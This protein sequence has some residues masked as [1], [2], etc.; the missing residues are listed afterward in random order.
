MSPRESSGAAPPGQGDP[1]SRTHV[2]GTTPTRAQPAGFVRLRI[3]W[4]EKASRRAGIISNCYVQWSR[5]MKG[6][7]R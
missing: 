7:P 4:G 5:G 3:V 1:S 2:C 6:G